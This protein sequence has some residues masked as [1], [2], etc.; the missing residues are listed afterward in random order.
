[1]IE[2]LGKAAPIRLVCQLMDYPRSSYY[3]WLRREPQ[4]DQ[5]LLDQVDLVRRIHESNRG[6][7]G[8]RRMVR[9]L[10]NRGLEVGRH[11][12]RTLMRRAG[13]RA[14]QHR[15]HKYQS[16]GPQALTVPNVLDRQFNPEVPN[17]V[18]AG[19]ITYIPTQQGWLYLAIVVDL[20]SRRVVGW[21]H[22]HEA[23]AWL[24][25]RALQ[26]ALR[27]RR[28]GGGLLF[29][30]DQGRQYTSHAMAEILRDNG[31]TQ[32]MSRKGNCWDNAVV[33]RVF[34]TLKGEWLYSKY[35]SRQEAVADI[36]Q[37]VDWYN[38]RRLHTANGLVPPAL[39]EAQAA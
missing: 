2:E 23:G 38:H 39:H 28:P 16:L 11:R 1:M 15:R 21:A 36:E 34:A 13:V 19:D 22:S 17:R 6:S 9:E 10:S 37:F 31:I 32:S 33:E 26:G 35:P 29:H 30:S 14:R 4:I 27:Q 8:S 5:E 25:V 12:A 18:W 3:A 20:F 7:Y 24:A